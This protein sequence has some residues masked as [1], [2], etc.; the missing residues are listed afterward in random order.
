MG[1]FDRFSV[2][3]THAPIQTVRQAGATAGGQTSSVRVLVI[4]THTN[5]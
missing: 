4:S 1:I 5:I 2:T 3:H